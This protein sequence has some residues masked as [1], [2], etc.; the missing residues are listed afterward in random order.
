MTQIRRTE[1]LHARLLRMPV[2]GKANV[3]D[4]DAARLSR[5][6]SKAR[7]NGETLR[8]TT[9]STGS[10]GKAKRGALRTLLLRLAAMGAACLCREFGH[11]HRPLTNSLP[12]ET[13]R[14]CD[15]R[16]R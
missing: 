13:H 11:T 12:H 8:A 14:R 16:L 7:M 4:D 10:P 5:P 3:T 2:S 6:L 1:K 15:H 9:K